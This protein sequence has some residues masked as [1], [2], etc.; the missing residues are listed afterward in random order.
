MVHQDKQI[1][2]T[3]LSASEGLVGKVEMI[4]SG[5]LSRVTLMVDQ[6]MGVDEKGLAHG[7]F[8]F[9]LADYA[10]MVAVNDPF[11]VLLSSRVRF[12]K[13]V[14]VGDR[15]TAHARITET[16]GKR[17]KVWCEVFKQDETKVF[18]GEFLCLS[19]NKHILEK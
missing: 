10:A 2:E 4:E 18:E 15:L 12:L 14:V 1:Q 3:H 11:V 5:R 13:P 17:N 7:G 9:G 8:T 6:G 16:E 19:L